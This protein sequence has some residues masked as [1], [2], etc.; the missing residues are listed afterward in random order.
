[1]S[2]LRKEF[3]ENGY[4][5]KKNFLIN[6]NFKRIAEEL[7]KQIINKCSEIELSKI[8]GSIIGNLNLSP[9]K[10]GRELLNLLKL[11][12]FEKI[13]EELTEKKIND[14]DI[15]IGGNLALPFKHNQH[16]HIDGNYKD[17]M[18]LAS[19]ATSNVDENSGPTEIIL[20]SHAKFIPYWKFLIS[21]K[22]KYKLTMSLGDLMIRKHCIWHRGTINNTNNPRFIIAFLIFDKLRKVAPNP[23]ENNNDIVIYNNFFGNSFSERIKE[24]IYVKCKYIF[25]LYKILYSIIKNK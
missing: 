22:R 5:I 6:D 19:I 3:L 2:N 4:I 25:G 12:N 9:G 8:G 14:L 21:K 20:N 16:F 24:F 15:R 11:S 17:E 23:H 13:I 10:Y 7:N 1:M 18:L